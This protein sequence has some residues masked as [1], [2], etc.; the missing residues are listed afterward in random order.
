[1]KILLAIILLVSLPPLVMVASAFYHN[2]LP[3][4]APPGPLARLKTY[5]G[6]HVARTAEQHP[7]A[8]LRSLHVAMPLA[9]LRKK[10]PEIIT[11]LGWD[12]E[13]DDGDTLH[14]VVT[15]ALL[16]YRDDIHISLRPLP[17][18]GTAVDV[19]SVSRVGHGDLGTN[20]RHVLDLYGAITANMSK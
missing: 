10:L 12:I 14:A 6:T 16:K 20:T 2:D 19:E 17:E 5:I 3:W 7:Y 1:M 8:E 11:G 4:T 15:T 13:A 9:Q 18:G